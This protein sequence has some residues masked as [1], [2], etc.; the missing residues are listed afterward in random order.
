MALRF[1][2]T[3]GTFTMTR[4]I[5][6]GAALFL[7]LS[8]AACSAQPSAPPAPTPVAQAEQPGIVLP[9]GGRK[10]E[11][12][13]VHMRDGARLNADVYLPAGEGKFPVVLVRTPYKTEISRRPVF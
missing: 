7:A 2:E 10:L 3:G 4:R 1:G 12:L 6:Q 5:K 11:A 9:K 13:Q 8:F